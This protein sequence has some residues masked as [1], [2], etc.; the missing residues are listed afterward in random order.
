MIHGYAGK[1]TSENGVDNQ[2]GNDVLPFGAGKSTQCQRHAHVLASV[3][4]VLRPFLSFLSQM[5]TNTLT[6]TAKKH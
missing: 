2:K 5:C 3:E 4:V 6:Q 1:E